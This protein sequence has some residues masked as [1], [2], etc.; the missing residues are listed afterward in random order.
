MRSSL[1]GLCDEVS[2]DEALGD[3][4]AGAGW[5]YHET[6]LLESSMMRFIL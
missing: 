5:S 3:W 6:G 4:G 1:C 2:R